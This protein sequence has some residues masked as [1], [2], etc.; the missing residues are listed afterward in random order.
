MNVNYDFIKIDTKITLAAKAKRP[1]L[2]RLHLTLAVFRI[3]LFHLVSRHP[4]LRFPDHGL[5]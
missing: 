3:S 4:P 1:D 5:H 2:E